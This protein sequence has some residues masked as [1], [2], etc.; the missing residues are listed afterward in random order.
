MFF[1]VSYTIR[2]YTF[3]IRIRISY[4]AA[5]LVKGLNHLL[6]LYLALSLLY[7]THL[8]YLFFSISSILMLCSDASARSQPPSASVPRS[9]P[10]YILFFLFSSFYL[11][12]C[13][14]SLLMFRSDASERPQ[15]PAASLPRPILTIYS[16]LFYSI[17]FNSILSHSIVSCHKTRRK[18][19]WKYLHVFHSIP[20]FSIRF[21]SITFHS[22]PFHSILFYYILFY[23]FLFY[24][25][26]P[27][28]PF[29]NIPFHSIPF[30]S[31][32]F[33]SILFYFSIPSLP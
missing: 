33:H 22:I 7:S 27:F 24:S 3:W 19:W 13:I 14:S 4:F 26:L 25:I 2:K 8:Y 16:V 1:F 11:F 29:L 18:F 15:P 17:L 30:H 6:L 9:V 28:P 5:K 23:S 20:F 31:T 12:Y 10:T 21:H 32:P